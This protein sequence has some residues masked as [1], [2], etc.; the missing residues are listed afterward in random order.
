MALPAS[1][2]RAS[3]NGSG[4]ICLV[5]DNRLNLIGG[6][7]DDAAGCLK[8]DTASS[9]NAG[10][11]YYAWVVWRSASAAIVHTWLDHGF[12]SPSDAM[13]LRLHSSI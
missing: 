4:L 3:T 5:A 7:K 11:Q 2:V 1:A 13:Q 9:G 8:Q 6:H 12:F 10:I